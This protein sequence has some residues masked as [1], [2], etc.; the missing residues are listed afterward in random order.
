[1]IREELDDARQGAGRVGGGDD[2]ARDDVPAPEPTA[3]T[4][5]VPPASTPP[6]N[7]T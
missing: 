2:P 3:Q 4:T 5:F 7:V 6:Y 1:M